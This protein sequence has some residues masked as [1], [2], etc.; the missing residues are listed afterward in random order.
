MDE[1]DNS[2][3]GVY[4]GSTGDILDNDFV[5]MRGVPAAQYSFDNISG[6]TTISILLAVSTIQKAQ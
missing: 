6:G 2:I 3:V 4:V 1:D 5:T